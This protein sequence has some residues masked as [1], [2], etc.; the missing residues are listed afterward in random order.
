MESPASLC[1]LGEPLSVVWSHLGIEELG[2][3]ARAKRWESSVV[4]AQCKKL[5]VLIL[6]PLL[7]LQTLLREYHLELDKS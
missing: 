5:D 4:E 6:R 3:V 7:T 2:M 1:S